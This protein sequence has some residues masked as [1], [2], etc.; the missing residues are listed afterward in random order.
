MDYKSSMN[1]G[2]S[3]LDYLTK[4]IITKCP[5]IAA[6]EEDLKHVQQASRGISFHWSRYSHLVK[7]K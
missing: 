7:S 2:I 5:H 4:V 6:L 3:V 1:K